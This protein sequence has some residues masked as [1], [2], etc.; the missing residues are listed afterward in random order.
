MLS[1]ANPPAPAG[2][3]ALSGSGAPTGT[4]QNY[5][6]QLQQLS[7]MGINDRMVALQALQA[8]GGDIHLALEIIYGST[9]M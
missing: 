1:S 6:S 9:D 7:D 2:S 8:A 3:G 4:V 5:E